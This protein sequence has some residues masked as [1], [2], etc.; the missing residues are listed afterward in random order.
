LKNEG[1]DIHNFTTEIKKASGKL[2]NLNTNIYPGFE[3]VVFPPICSMDSETLIG[4]LKEVRKNEL[5]GFVLSWDISKI[6]EN[7]FSLVGDFFV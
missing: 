1:L 3:A 7:Y 6:P 4:Y 5:K 2:V